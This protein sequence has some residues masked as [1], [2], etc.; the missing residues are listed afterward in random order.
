MPSIIA[1]GLTLQDISL[2]AVTRGELYVASSSGGD[3]DPDVWEDLPVAITV[4]DV[5]EGSMALSFFQASMKS[6]TVT[7]QFQLR[8]V[9]NDTPQMASIMRTEGRLSAQWMPSC[10]FAFITH[11]SAGTHEFRIQA[12]C[13]STAVDFYWQGLRHVVAILKR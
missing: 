8:C 12:Q 6:K 7:R 11:L 1:G 13:S 2:H 5:P 4:D 10:T 3:W 9:W